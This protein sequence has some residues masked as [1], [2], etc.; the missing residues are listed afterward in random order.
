V[1]SPERVEVLPDYLRHELTGTGLEFVKV[2]DENSAYTR[3]QISYL[4][5]GL[6]ISGIM[7]IP[8]GDGKYP[9]V[10]LNHGH[11]DTDIYTLGR[12]LKREQDYLARAGFAVVHTDYRNHAF[13][14]KDLSI[15]EE[16]TP[17]RSRK[18]GSDSMNAII[19]VREA[20]KR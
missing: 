17:N 6:K 5:D 14:D 15:I 8:K 13:S 4:S 18:Y 2:L 12:G 11:I 7:N 3:Y 19:A 9:L 10:I 1:T 20:V 16:K